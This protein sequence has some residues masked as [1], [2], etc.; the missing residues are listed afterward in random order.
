VPLLLLIYKTELCH[1][2]DCKIAVECLEAQKELLAVNR[3][4]MK[5]YITGGILQAT[6][7]SK[8]IPNFE[9]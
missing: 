5:Q 9:W 1:C 4:V 6:R 8:E 3:N 2:L 7:A